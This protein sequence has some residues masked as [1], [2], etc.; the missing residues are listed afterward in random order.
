MWWDQFEI[1]LD[2][3]FNAYSRSEGRDIH[4]QS[5]KLRILTKK[6][7][8]DFLATTK[9]AIMTQMITIPM[10]M[11][12]IQALATFRQEVNHKFAPN[13]PSGRSTRRVQQ[14]KWGRGRGR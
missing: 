7:N 13:M 3:A 5:M 2:F 9:A 4:S 1:D 6:V 8:V 10:G 14:F 11:T 12:Y